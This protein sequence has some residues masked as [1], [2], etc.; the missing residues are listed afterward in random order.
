[1]VM[2][3]SPMA[4][5]IVRQ[6]RFAPG[7]SQ[8][9]FNPVFDLDGVRTRKV[10]PRGRIRE[11]VI[12]LCHGCLVVIPV[13]EFG[14]DH[15][16]VLELR[17]RAGAESEFAAEMSDMIGQR[18][19]GRFGSPSWLIINARFICSTDPSVWSRSGCAKATTD[20]AMA[21][22]DISPCHCTE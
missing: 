21:P 8:E 7:A 18:V 2:P 20:S 3:A 16:A 11:V 15:I 22:I 12:R 10:E 17:H 19:N 4:D 6:T 1:M 13:A 9:F 14:H 5:F